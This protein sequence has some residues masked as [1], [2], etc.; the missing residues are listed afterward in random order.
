MKHWKKHPAGHSNNGC[1]TRS[2]RFGCIANNL[3]PAASPD[4]YDALGRI[5]LPT[6]YRAW[7]ASGQNGLVGKAV[8][9]DPIERNTVTA[10]LHIISPQ[11]GTTYFLD[12]DLPDQGSHLRLQTSANGNVLWRSDTMLIQQNQAGTFAIM[13]AGRHELIARDETTGA[14]SRTWISVKPL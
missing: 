8:V 11:P 1:I 10:N 14:E 9:D 5:R 7:L 12:P 4:D 13:S 3:P 2:A 6:E